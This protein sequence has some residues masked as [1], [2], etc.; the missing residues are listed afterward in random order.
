MTQGR[1]RNILDAYRAIRP[2]VEVGLRLGN[3]C[4]YRGRMAKRL[5]SMMYRAEGAQRIPWVIHQAYLSNYSP[6][7]D[8]L[9]SIGPG[10]LAFERR[11]EFRRSADVIQGRIDCLAA[12]QLV[13]HFR[14]A[15]TQTPIGHHDQ[16]AVGGPQGVSG[17]G[18]GRK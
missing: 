16:G 8:D 10:V 15:V 3:I 9:L 2:P 13:D 17:C 6:T 14:R 12:S 7:V 18:R 11:L 5:R 1:F 4:L